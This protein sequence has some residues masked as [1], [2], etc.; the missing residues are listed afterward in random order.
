MFYVLLH[1]SIASTKSMD[2]LRPFPNSELPSTCLH[3]HP[4]GAPLEMIYFTET[5]VT[6]ELVYR[7]WDILDK[8]SVLNFLMPA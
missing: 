1:H 7:L 6:C 5:Y 4:V 3:M 2:L 8:E